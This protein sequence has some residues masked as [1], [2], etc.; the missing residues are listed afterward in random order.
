MA[1]QGRPGLCANSDDL[2][3]LKE[4]K[5]FNCMKQSPVFTYI[6]LYFISLMI[7]RFITDQKLKSFKNVPILFN[8]CEA[9]YLLTLRYI[10]RFDG[11]KQQ[12]LRRYFQ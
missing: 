6:L 10:L 4:W 1:F 12:Q 5:V 8:S 11:N 7:H 3:R 2:V 9:S